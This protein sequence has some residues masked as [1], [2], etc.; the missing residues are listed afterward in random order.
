MCMDQLY[1]MLPNEFAQSADIRNVESSV[2]RNDLDGEP[3]VTRRVENPARP[4][5]YGAAMPAPRFES[6]CKLQKHGFR[7]TRPRGINEMQYLSA[8]GHGACRAGGALQDTEGR[9]RIDAAAGML[10]F[11]ALSAATCRETVM[12]MLNQKNG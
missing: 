6:R 5:D 7:T 12:A 2:C 4:D 9:P 11:R 8:R 3:Q 10:S 1:T